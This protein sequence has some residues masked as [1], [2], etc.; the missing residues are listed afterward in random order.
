[1]I[2]LVELVDDYGHDI[3]FIGTDYKKAEESFDAVTKHL[4]L[5]EQDTERMFGPM[6]PDHEPV[7]VEYRFPY[8]NEDVN[9]SF[10][11]K[12]SDIGRRELYLK[13]YEDNWTEP[14][15]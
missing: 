4:K 11:A 3:Y 15:N 7:I 2:Y 12:S 5:T 14:L 8:K 1:M 9:I 6:G 13:Q 10:L